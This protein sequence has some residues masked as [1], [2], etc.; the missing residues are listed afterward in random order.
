MKFKPGR[1]RFLEISTKGM[2]A[3]GIAPFVFGNTNR[4]ETPTVDDIKPIDAP[5]QMPQLQR[6]VFPDRI[7]DIRNF[8]AVGDGKTKNTLAFSK[9]IKKCAE[10]GGG[11]VL[12]PPGKWHTGAIH[13]KSNINLH[14]KTDAEIHFS[15]NPEDYLPVVFTRWAGFELMN[16]SPF[17]YA[18][19]CENIGI[20]GSG[21]LFGHGEK[22]WNWKKREDGLDG[23]GMRIY[24]KMVLLNV[25]PEKRIF[26]N[27]DEG[28][29]PQFISPINCRN[30]LLEDFTIAG[31]GPFW[32][33][34]FVYCENVIARGLTLF[35]IGGPNNDGINMDSTRNALIEHCQINSNDDS[36]ALK[37]GVNEDGRRVGRPT[38]NIVVRHVKCNPSNGGYAIGSEMS[39]DVR[40]VYFHDCSISE[41]RHGIRLKSNASRGGIVEHIWFQNI[42]M[43]N[44]RGAAI[45]INTGYSAWM[46]D[47]NGT[48]YPKF[49]DIV[50]SGIACNGAAAV[51][52]VNGKKEQPIERIVLKN[53]SAKAQKGM[54]FNWIDGLNMNNIKLDVATGEPVMIENCNNVTN[55]F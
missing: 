23:Q 20:T 5:F 2:I 24:N 37:S 30:V 13:L 4:F 15:D 27:P 47:V 33:I 25:A 40:N 35:S 48:A 22:W 55:N 41:S 53:I 42:N 32:T 12:V 54:N 26:G 49:R 3:F 8:G 14:L 16:Y 36:I 21:K 38:E 52:L 19:G 46:S 11:K 44:I 50:F 10:E 31:G 1:R 34:Q 17:I 39:G 45:D 29:R 51:V 28:L 9:A 43:D 18:N 7:Y 6:P